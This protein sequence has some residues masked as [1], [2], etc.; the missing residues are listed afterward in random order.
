[1]KIYLRQNFRS[2]LNYV[3]ELLFFEDEE[4]CEGE[5]LEDDPLLLESVDVEDDDSLLLEDDEAL[6]EPVEVDN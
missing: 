1:M 5:E 6:D 3:E 4:E 2:S